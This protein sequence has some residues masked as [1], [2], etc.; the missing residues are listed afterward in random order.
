MRSEL[1]EALQ[2]GIDALASVAGL[3][4]QTKAGTRFIAWPVQSPTVVAGRI[5]ASPDSNSYFETSA[6]RAFERAEVL[7][8]DDGYTYTVQAHFPR[9][10]TTGIFR[11]AVGPGRA[12]K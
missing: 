7:K 10:P 1:Q 9:N 2:E 6:A 3:W 12:A 4:F 5:D 8:C 11:F